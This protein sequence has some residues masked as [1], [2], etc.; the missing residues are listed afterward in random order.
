MATSYRVSLP[1]SAPAPDTATARERVIDALGRME[2][3]ERNALEEMRE[4]LCAMACALK[5][6]GASSDE[7]LDEVRRVIAGPVIETGGFRLHPAAREAL[8][9]L[10]LYWCAAELGRA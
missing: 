2:Q 5:A 1:T 6:D 8:V 10:S 9:E 3:G 7:S 4:A